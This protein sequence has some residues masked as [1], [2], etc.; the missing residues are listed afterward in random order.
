[1]PTPPDRDIGLS[2][3][4]TP[5]IS[6][7]DF[8]GYRSLSRGDMP[9]VDRAMMVE[10]DRIM[11]DELAIGLIQMMENAG[12]SLARLAHD[13]LA[14]AAGRVLALAG[15][16]G[17]GGGVLTAARRLA[18]WGREVNVV[19]TSPKA[20]FTGVPEVQLRSVEA[21]GIYVSRYLPPAVDDHDILLDGLVG[22]SLSGALRG[23]AA[24]AAAF[25]N[26]RRVARCIS[27]DVPSGFDAASGRATE[28]S[29]RPDAILTIAAPKKGLADAYPNVP[30]LVADISV[31]AVVF[32][33]VAGR[34]FAPPADITRM[35]G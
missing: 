11:E 19:L 17:N 22:Y 8:S 14:G 20:D 32:E 18:G 27:L 15:R 9:V 5:P 31:P 1:M 16:G 35:A 26:T 4:S 25:I 12:R 30:V 34:A 23:A 21:I 29:V 7:F 10:V 24:E 3:M 13:Q 6:R 33:R 2:V 28:A